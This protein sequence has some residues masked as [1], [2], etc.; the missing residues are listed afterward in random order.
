MGENLKYWELHQYASSLI[1]LN[2]TIS[3]TTC[4]SH[5]SKNGR[6]VHIL[7]YD[8]QSNVPSISSE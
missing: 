6:V 7:F 4:V 1:I 5:S 8:S 3:E 2:V